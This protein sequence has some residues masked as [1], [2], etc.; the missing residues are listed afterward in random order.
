M[1]V[2]A[3]E[4]SGDLH[5]GTLARALRA[6][7]PGLVLHG[8]GGA[9]M[10]QAG[11]RL[12]YG[13]ERGSV[14]GATEVVGRLPALVRTLLALRRWLRT[15]RPRGVVLIDFPDFNL[16]LARAARRLGIPVAYFMAPQ[17]WAWRRGRLKAMARDVSRVLAVFPFEMTV[18]Q[19]AGV[20]VEFVGH[21]ILDALP[22]LDR[23][24]ARAGLVEGEGP[25]VGL[26]PGSRAAEI[27]RLLP[28]MLGAAREI[29]GPPPA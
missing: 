23:D 21:P 5:G 16:R 22:P 6:R 25:L 11:V 28:V 17:V 15:A 26:L 27:R 2:I 10:A 8:M 1:L 20:P 13:I 12:L 18:Y 24:T 29:A 4:A 7:A 14:V 9:R 3:G 19:E